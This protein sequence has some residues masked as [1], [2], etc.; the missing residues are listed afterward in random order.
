MKITIGITTFNR[1]EYLKRLEQSLSLVDG[2]ES[3][4]IRLYDDCST[5]L[6]IE[7]IESLFPHA[8]D[9][10]RRSE[11]L[12][13]DR[14]LRQ[15]YVDFLA[16]NDDVLVTMDS[17]LICRPDWII[18][19][20][21]YFPLTEGVMSLYH[22]RLHPPTR[23]LKLNGTV[24][25]EKNHI[26]AAG[27]MMSREVIEGIIRH[28]PPGDSFDWA[29]SDFLRRKGIPMLVSR[30]SYFQHLG[31]QGFHCDGISTVDV[32][33]NFKPIH[34]LNRQFLAESRK[35]LTEIRRTHFSSD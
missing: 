19:T 12:G 4:P 6:S 24:F 11:N 18:F 8:T 5:E 3:C 30:E 31:V 10:V 17:D 13:P 14:N 16:T 7:E 22:S 9:I 33:L 29:W 32:G 34:S 2:L 26:G 23:R 21:K 35:E 28:I 15:M 20:K 1:K 27:S 25:Y